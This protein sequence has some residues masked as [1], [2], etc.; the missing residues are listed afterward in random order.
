M[1]KQ[2]PSETVS[3]LTDMFV[4]LCAVNAMK[5]QLISLPED[6]QKSVKDLLL[7][8]WQEE[9]QKLF[10]QRILGFQEQ[11][12]QLPPSERLTANLQVEKITDQFKVD[13]EFAKVIVENII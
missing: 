13:I 5:L 2:I 8:Q 9:S 1:S 7:K 11:I 6:Q 3:L 12:K 4:K 10:D